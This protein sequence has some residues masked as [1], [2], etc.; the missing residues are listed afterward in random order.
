MKLFPRCI[1]SPW[2]LYWL[3]PVGQGA[4]SWNLVQGCKAFTAA[5]EVGAE[6]AVDLSAKW[7]LHVLCEKYPQTWNTSLLARKI[8]KTIHVWTLYGTSLFELF[9]GVWLVKHKVN[10]ASWENS[11]AIQCVPRKHN[12]FCKIG[13]SLGKKLQQSYNL[14]FPCQGIMPK[15]GIPHKYQ[16]GTWGTRK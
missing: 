13:S 1:N 14:Y 4:L 2:D 7:C 16:N 11:G 15:L 5:K 3:I 6:P 12:S 9:L 10:A 8:S